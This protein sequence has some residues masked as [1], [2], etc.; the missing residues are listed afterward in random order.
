MTNHQ[1]TAEGESSKYRSSWSRPG[2]AERNSEPIA[3]ALAPL[4]SPSSSSRSLAILEIASGFGHQISAIAD[5]YSDCQFHPSEAS[6]HLR[7]QIDTATSS[8]PNV[9]KAEQLDVLDQNDWLTLVHNLSGESSSPRL[10]DEGLFDGI[11]VCNF[12]HITPWNVTESL[13][14]HIDPRV[15]YVTQS[16]YRSLLNKHS[17]FIAIYGAFNENGTFTSEGNKA[18]DA[19]IRARDPAFGL[20][21]IDSE[22]KPLAWRHGYTLADRIEMPAGNLMLVLKVREE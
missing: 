20:R 8:L 11:V 15:G 17:G 14:S 1:P 12:T 13:F 7:N 5:R 22:L 16:G 18:F 4:L 2:S 6:S 9:S 21:D 3:A 19:E 10:E